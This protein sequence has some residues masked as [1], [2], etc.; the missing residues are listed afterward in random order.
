MEKTCGLLSKKL[1]LMAQGWPACLQMIAAT[2]M[3]VKA[4]DKI[5]MGQEL[6][7]TAAHAIERT[8]KNLPSL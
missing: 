5:T 4:A 7:I 3:L 8:L 2:A 6:V 1:D